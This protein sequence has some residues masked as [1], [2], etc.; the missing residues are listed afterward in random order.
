MSDTPNSTR[1]PTAIP[2]DRIRNERLTLV[3]VVDT[4]AR[5]R[6]GSHVTRLV[7]CGTPSSVS[8]LSGIRQHLGLVADSMQA[9][10]FLPD[11]SNASNELY[12]WL[13][14]ER[15]DLQRIGMGWM[16]FYTFNA[17]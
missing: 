7:T 1:M 5:A 3:V 17:Y 10:C 6:C 2:I 16:W 4:T 14:I 11:I 9:Q 13:I 15:N 12:I 8:R